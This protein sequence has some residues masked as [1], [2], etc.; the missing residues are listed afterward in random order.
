MPASSETF[1]RFLHRTYWRGTG[2]N[3]FFSRRIRPAGLGLCCTLIVTSMLGVGEQR[4]PVYLIFS[5]AVALGLI[6]VPWAML[7]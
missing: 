3:Y 5:F 6:A 2:I 7:R 1:R 4:A